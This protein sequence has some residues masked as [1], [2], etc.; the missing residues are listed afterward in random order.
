MAVSMLSQ[1]IE[2]SEN[3]EADQNSEVL[4][5]VADYFMGLATFVNDSNVNIT[6]TVSHNFPL[7]MSAWASKR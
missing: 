6:A 1:V 7:S 5:T 2:P 3:S 4:G